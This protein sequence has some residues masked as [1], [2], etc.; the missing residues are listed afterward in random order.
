MA[1]T[2]LQRALQYKNDRGWNVI[3]LAKDA[4]VPA[5]GFPLSEFFG[6]KMTEAEM[7]DWFTRDS[8]GN[9]GVMVGPTS[10]LW[11]VDID[12]LSKVAEWQQAYPSDLMSRTPSGGIHLFYQY[13]DGLDL[14]NG[15]IGS[16]VDVFGRDHYVLVAPS[17][18]KNGEHDGRRYSGSYE[19][20]KY[21][22]PSRAP[23]EVI[24][25]ALTGSGS[26]ASALGSQPVKTVNVSREEAM[27]LLGYA[28]RYGKFFPG[29]HNETIYYG[30][31]VLAGDGM[32][33]DLILEMMLGF[34]GRDESPQGER[35]VRAAV[36]NAV[37][38]AQKARE[39]REAED[40][41][42]G[43]I[44]SLG[45]GSSAPAPQLSSN[46]SSPASPS[47]PTFN[48]LTYEQ[49]A[50]EYEGYEAKWLVDDWLMED[51]VI[52]LAAP[53]ERYKTWLASDLAVSVCTGLP[54]LGQYPV[55]KTGD[56]LVIQQ[57]DFGAR[58]ISRFNMIENAKTRLLDCGS[59]FNVRE[60]DEGGVW[61]STEFNPNWNTIH[62]HTDASLKLDDPKSLASFKEKV[63]ELKPALVIIDPFYSL[64]NK[65]DDYYASLADTIRQHI[66]QL[67]N[68]V[69]CSFVFVHHTGKGNKDGNDPTQREGAWGS[70]FI[71]AAMEGMIMLSRQK[72]QD[73]KTVTVYRRF[74]DAEAPPV[75][76]VSFIIKD[77]EYNVEFGAGDSLETDVKMYL[78]ENGPTPLA[79]LFE[80]FGDKFS[81]KPQ[82]TNWLRE[83]EGIVKEK[84][85]IYTLAP[86]VRLDV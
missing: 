62:F 29:R 40:D 50:Q 26:T 17:Y 4:K 51:S 24:V 47:R 55:R 31:L 44:I 12:D 53:P 33:P 81:S 49:I 76:S 77:G 82:L 16:G 61:L 75:V 38:A 46:N 14:P 27:N 43:V 59:G 54:F 60:D 36:N 65:T 5:Q 80:E 9:V 20:V 63:R 56:V 64:S 83:T 52:M 15:H 66:K 58:L 42:A 32:H 35:A 19:W 25:A 39:T 18:V 7:Q 13:P 68:E 78:L 3:P 30:S 86:D 10:G 74:K 69:G 71:N 73:N 84:R 85:G 57:E 34:D 8:V 28:M 1:A 22:Q 48:T 67:R 70:Q 21:G 11:V 41:F 72:G 37:R 6:R 45:E 23:Q 2:L 79:E